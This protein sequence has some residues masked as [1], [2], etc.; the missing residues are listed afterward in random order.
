MSEQ[1]SFDDKLVRKLAEILNETHLSEIE[2]QIGDVRLK[3]ARQ[4]TLPIHHT[5]FPQLQSVSQPSLSSIINPAS[6]TDK[7]MDN[8]QHPGAIKAPMVGT[9]YAS[10]TPGGT[11]FIQVGSDVKVGQTLVIIEAMK[12]MN[13]IRAPKDGK[14]SQIFFKDGDPVEYDHVLLIIE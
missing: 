5:T 3:V 1:F 7:S 10:A 12:V 8:A 6:E 11:P 4:A 13:Q 2:Y 9:V 14:I